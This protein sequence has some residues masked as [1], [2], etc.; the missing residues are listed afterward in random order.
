MYEYASGGTADSVHNGVDLASPTG[1]PVAA[2]AAG[3]V[4]LAAPRLVTGLTVVLEHLPG[5]YTLYYHLSGM[6]VKAGER[7]SAGQT[8][9]RVGS[10]GLATGPHLHWEARAGSVAVDPDGLT[11]ERIVDKSAVFGIIG[12]ILVPERR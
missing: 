4:V 8:I 6:E 2:A 1:T 11:L 3:V 5:L 9:G 12:R 10:T 7:V